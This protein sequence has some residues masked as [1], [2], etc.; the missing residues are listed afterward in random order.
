MTKPYTPYKFISWQLLKSGTYISTEKF[1]YYSERYNKMIT[2]P[3][4]TWSDGATLAPDLLSNGWGVHDILRRCK[5][6]DDVSPCSNFQASMILFD[7]LW[8]ERR[9]VNAPIWAIGTYLWG[10]LPEKFRAFFRK[11]SK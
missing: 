2:L 8:E 11:G 5:T 6:F 1:T 7:I 4:G 10:S 9:Y 3:K